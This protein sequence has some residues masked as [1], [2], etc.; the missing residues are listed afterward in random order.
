M[1]KPK[2]VYVTFIA[3]T[4]EKLWEALT[5][6]E[7]TRQ[8][9]TGRRM[10]SDWKTG[11]PVRHTQE[12]FGFDWEGK[13]LESDPPRLLSYTFEPI[14]D[15]PPRY[16]PIGG[17]PSRVTFALE[18]VGSVVKLTVTHD[19]LTEDACRLISFGW[20]HGL[21]SLKSLLET[22]SPLVFDP[23]A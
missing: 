15:N 20:P 12:Q 10:F 19:E 11:S 21:S 22:G 1:D 16:D 18:Q 3:T 14:A 23:T 4:A 17:S 5:S 2:F 13:V 6:E 9:W 8:W 7:F